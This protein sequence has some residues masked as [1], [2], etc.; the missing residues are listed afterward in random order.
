MI[1]SSV[2]SWII[3]WLEVWALLIPLF[4]LIKKPGQPVYMRPVIYYLFIALFLNIVIILIWKRQTL[5]L[6]TVFDNNNPVYNLHAIARLIFFSVF[7]ILLKQPFLKWVK[8]IIPFLFIFFVVFNF[9]FFEYY[10]QPK[11]STRL[12]TVESGILLFQKG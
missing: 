2:F 4:V 7:F 5:G 9:I 8:W 10:F 6:N 12:H 11:I 1:L 3:I